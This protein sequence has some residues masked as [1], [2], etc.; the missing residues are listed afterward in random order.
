MTKEKKEE[1]DFNTQSNY[2]LNVQLFHNRPKQKR[3]TAAYNLYKHSAT[4]SESSF[5]P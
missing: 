3:I 1:I 5:S 2:W 4:V